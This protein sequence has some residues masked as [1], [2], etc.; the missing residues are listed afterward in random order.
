[1]GQRALNLNE[2]VICD[3]HRQGIATRKIAEAQDCA[4]TTIRKVLK[5][6]GITL[7]P[8]NVRKTGVSDA[9]I[10]ACYKRVESTIKAGKELGVSRETVARVCRKYNVRLIGWKNNGGNG[11]DPRK[12]TDSELAEEAKTMNC[13]EIAIRHNMSEERVWRRARRLG[14][15]LD[16]KGGGGHH[17]RRTRFYGHAE[18]DKSI[19]LKALYKRDKGICQLCGKPTDPE[20]IKDGHISRMYP[21]IDHIMPL[22]KGGAHTWD[23]VQLAHMSCNAG[24]R[25]RTAAAETEVSR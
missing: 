11:G 9:E 15:K 21:T 16:A 20:D 19:T 25:D 10:L 13:R 8:V 24:K 22:S 17:Y 1:M 7:T 12:I 4:V 23:N 3:M 2:A 14:I 6:N 5:R 18:Y